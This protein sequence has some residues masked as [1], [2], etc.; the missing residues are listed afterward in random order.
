MTTPI[1]LLSFFLSR[2][3]LNE[4]NYPCSSGVPEEAIRQRLSLKPVISSSR[5]KV[6]RKVGVPEEA[7]AQ[8]MQ[9]DASSL[10]TPVFRPPKR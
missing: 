3:S 6:M 2:C 8:R 1:L 4:P 10:T 9:V 5:Y 7:V